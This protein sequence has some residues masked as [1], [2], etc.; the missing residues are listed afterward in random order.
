M[1]YEDVLSCH[2]L[3][4]LSDISDGV[5]VC[6]S[7]SWLPFVNS[8]WTKRGKFILVDVYILFLYCLLSFSF[9]KKPQMLT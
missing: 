8:K 7:V 3:V 6:C 1:F 2:G 5:F 9:K 4:Y